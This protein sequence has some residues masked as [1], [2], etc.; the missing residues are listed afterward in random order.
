MKEGRSKTA[1]KE[2]RGLGTSCNMLGRPGTLGGRRLRWGRFG[3]DVYL[4][5]GSLW[6]LGWGRLMGTRFS[7]VRGALRKCKSKGVGSLE[8]GD[9]SCFEVGQLGR[10]A[11]H[12]EVL[13]RFF[14]N[15]YGPGAYQ[16]SC[17]RTQTS[18]WLLDSWAAR[19]SHLQR[20]LLAKSSGKD[21]LYLLNL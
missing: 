9:T 19:F 18:A 4:S 15:A 7:G 3:E 12:G 20:K 8:D 10:S 13:L 1:F 2:T 14:S 17:G 5:C 6:L 16:E 11:S 21:I